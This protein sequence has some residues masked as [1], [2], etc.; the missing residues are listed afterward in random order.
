MSKTLVVGANGTVGRILVKELQYRGHDII[1]TTSKA[2]QGSSQRHLNLVTGEGLSQVFDG[3]DRAFFL[4]PA[5]PTNQHEL[6]NP[7]VDM[8]HEHKLDKVVMMTAIGVDADDNAPLRKAE[9]HLEQSGL[10]YNII[11]PNWFMQNFNTFWLEGIVKSQTIALPVGEARTSFIDARDI[12]ATAAAL[13]DGDAFDNQAFVLTG[14]ES[15]THDEAAAILS[16]VTGTTIGFSDITPEENRARLLAAGMPPTYVELLVM[17][18]AFVKAGYV[19]APTDAV[20]RI[21]GRRPFTFAQYAN[22]YR[23]AWS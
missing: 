13:L 23:Q 6:L 16:E 3:V 2:A 22:D 9:R 11:R 19:A 17:L 12:A 5:G 14:S 7:L 21:T 15:L 18:L 8:A 1:T 4:S 10:R 20:A